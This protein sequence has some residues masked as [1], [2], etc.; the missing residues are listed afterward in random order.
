M[1]D[2][3]F[4]YKN[5]ENVYKLQPTLYWHLKQNYSVY[6]GGT[7]LSALTFQVLPDWIVVTWVAGLEQ[8]LSYTVQILF[9]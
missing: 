3:V 4:V 5:S 8:V 9:G 2:K 1:V 6:P 7:F